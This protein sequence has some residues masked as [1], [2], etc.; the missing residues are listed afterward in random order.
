[1]FKRKHKTYLFVLTSEKKRKL[2]FS[3]LISLGTHAVKIL[4]SKCVYESACSTWYTCTV[5]AIFEKTSKVWNVSIQK[6]VVNVISL[7]TDM[8]RR[9]PKDFLLQEILKSFILWD[10]SWSSYSLLALG[11]QI[12]LCKHIVFTDRCGRQAS[13]QH[14]CLLALSVI[15]NMD[16]FGDHCI[17]TCFK[18]FKYKTGPFE[19][20][21]YQYA[22]NK[23]SLTDK[24]QSLATVS[25]FK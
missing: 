12:N 19:K 22:P 14:H 21:I 17:L 20:K 4:P 16:R 5:V 8:L 3:L 15:G 25:T 9:Q 13:V 23:H 24:K 11:K 2:N 18:G 1:M 7:K 10:W 6:D